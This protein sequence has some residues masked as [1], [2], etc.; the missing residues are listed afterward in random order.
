[1]EV[2]SELHASAGLPPEK[3]RST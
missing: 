1:M 2:R 3:N